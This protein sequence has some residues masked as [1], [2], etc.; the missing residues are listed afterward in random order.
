MIFGLLTVLAFLAQ[1]LI[2]MG[3]MPNFKSGRV[4]EITIC[5]GTDQVKVLVDENLNQVSPDTKNH[6]TDNSSSCIY[7]TT[8]GKDLAFQTFLFQQI[9]HLTYEAYV[10]R[11][12]GRHFISVIN[13]PYFGQGPPTFLS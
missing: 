4:F 2:P 9:E 3:Y 7:A 1:S 11:S 13:R 6:G 8:S 12:T 10:E 5:H